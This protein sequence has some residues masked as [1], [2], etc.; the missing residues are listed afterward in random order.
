MQGL[1]LII[2]MQFF[3]GLV[4]YR[5]P[6]RH[7]ACFVSLTAP[8]GPRREEQDA[9]QANIAV[10]VILIVSLVAGQLLLRHV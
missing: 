2:F 1:E 7:H 9:L 10:A 3:L 4:A 5:K 8:Y 6:Y